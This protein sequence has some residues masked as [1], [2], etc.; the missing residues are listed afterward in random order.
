MIPCTIAESLKLLQ[1]SCFTGRVFGLYSVYQGYLWLITIDHFEC[2]LSSKEEKPNLGGKPELVAPEL[3]KLVEAITC[4]PLNLVCQEEGT[5]NSIS[6]GDKNPETQKAFNVVKHIKQHSPSGQG[7]KLDV[8]ADSGL[9][10][11]QLTGSTVTGTAQSIIDPEAVKKPSSVKQSKL[12]PFPVSE[13]KSND[14]RDSKTSLSSQAGSTSATME[15][16]SPS[17]TNK[18]NLSC[19]SE[20][21]INPTSLD[22]L[23]QTKVQSLADNKDLST[24]HTE[25]IPI[26]SDLSVE[27]VRSSSSCS[28]T[29]LVGVKTSHVDTSPDLPRAQTVNPTGE[30]SSG[31]GSVVSSETQVVVIGDAVV[32]LFDSFS[33]FSKK[34]TMD[35][36]PVSPNSRITTSQYERN[37]IPPQQV[38]SEDKGQHNNLPESNQVD[39]VEYTLGTQQKAHLHDVDKPSTYPQSCQYGTDEPITSEQV[40]FMDKGERLVSLNPLHSH[41]RA[42]ALLASAEPHMNR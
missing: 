26:D 29:S 23:E 13:L 31:S 11:S 7:S 18:S 3:Q 38:T 14:H 24:C 21:Y 30:H 2:V 28:N 39:D 35:Q 36:C 25:E 37:V 10:N 15:T 32:P 17:E 27:G 4:N 16:E 22:T 41:I 40:S 6:R 12:Q 5:F 19:I 42:E 1:E 20:E 9:G 34:S 8:R 33:S